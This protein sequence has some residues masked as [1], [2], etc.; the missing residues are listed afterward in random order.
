M[1][2]LLYILFFL[3][4][5]YLLLASLVYLVQ[6]YFFFQ[7]EKLPHHFVFDFAIPFEEKFFYPEGQSAVI[8]A[9]HFTVQNPKGVVLYFKG[10]TRSIKGW[11]KFA[12]DFTNK[13]Y[14]VMMFDYRGF[15]KS[16]GVRT[17]ET[18]YADAQMVYDALKKQYKEEE[19]VIYGRSMGSGFA[20]RI[21]AD[22]QPRLL[23]LDA[24]YYSF[25]HLMRRYMPLLP[26]KRILKYKIH[27]DRFIENVNCPIHVFHGTQD[28]VIPFSA[29]MRLVRKVGNQARLISIRGGGHN[30][31]RN[32]PKYHEYLFDIL[33]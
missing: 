31:L 22:N 23:I 26:I 29:G 4:L 15:G 6:E 25:L 3:C 20:T 1:I 24:P 8:N 5:L 11:A 9:L 30:D 19:I 18:M 27:T 12:R 32:Y 33:V 28:M 14:D 21:A 7:P 13:G 17:E 2:Q 16:R 10:N